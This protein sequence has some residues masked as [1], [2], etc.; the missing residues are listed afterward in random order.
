MVSWWPWD[1]LYSMCRA[2]GT[3]AMD[4]NSGTMAVRP[5]GRPGCGEEVCQAVKGEPS[6][7]NPFKFCRVE[8]L[9]RL[10]EPVLGL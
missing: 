2:S 4:T 1:K 9:F 10:K 8:M 7:A 3:L 5:G 6:W